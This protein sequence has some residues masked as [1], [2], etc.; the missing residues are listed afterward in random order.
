MINTIYNCLVAIVNIAN[1]LHPFLP[2]SSAKVKYWLN[3][4]S[5]TWEYIDVKIEERVGEF[6]ILFERIDKKIIEEELSKLG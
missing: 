2:F 1:L 5:D 4:D 6:D 3:C